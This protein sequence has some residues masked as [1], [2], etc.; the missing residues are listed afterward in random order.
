MT[1]ET[2]NQFILNLQSCLSE[3]ATRVFK[4]IQM[5]CLWQAHIALPTATP[6]WN[7]FREVLKVSCRQ[8]KIKNKSLNLNHV[9]NAGQHVEVQYVILLNKMPAISKTWKVCLSVCC[10]QMAHRINR[11]LGSVH[12]HSPCFSCCCCRKGQDE[13][14][15]LHLQ[16]KEVIHM[17]SSSVLTSD[18]YQNSHPLKVQNQHCW[19]LVYCIMWKQIWSTP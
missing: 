5:R 1:T 13:I 19:P 14:F 17:Q 2:A 12:H 11:K 15:Y 16:Q 6:F 9:Q 8:N 4:A 18:T 10:S 7:T 3:T